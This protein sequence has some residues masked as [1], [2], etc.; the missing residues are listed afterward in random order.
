MTTGRM[1]AGLA[2]LDA[3]RGAGFL[4]SEEYA[5]VRASLLGELITEGPSVDRPPAAPRRPVVPAN[6]SSAW[7]VASVLL[8]TLGVVAAVLVATGRIGLSPWSAAPPP[9]VPVPSIE[10]TAAAPTAAPPAATSEDVLELE[11]VADGRGVEQLVGSWIPQLSAKQP[12]MT[13]DGV[14]YDYDEISRHVAS[15]KQRFPG[16]LLTWSGNFTTFR[17]PDFYVV[18]MPM[19]F[20]SA[21]SVIDWCNAQGLG[22]DDCLAKRLAH[23]GGPGGNTVYQR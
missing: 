5:T 4:T 17:Q 2:E 7:L 23:S 8:T 3:M 21:A 19:P 22:P 16:A 9:A 10:S 1:T 15:L 6:R 14:F 13:V 11:L 20:A 12:G 18:V